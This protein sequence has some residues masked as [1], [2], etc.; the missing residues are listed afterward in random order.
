MRKCGQRFLSE[1]SP[2]NQSQPGG[3]SWPGQLAWNIY[4]KIEGL[5]I[6]FKPSSVCMNAFVLGMT[7]REKKRFLTGIPQITLPSPMHVFIHLYLYV[8]TCFISSSS[9]F[10]WESSSSS[11]PW[12]S[13]LIWLRVKTWL[14]FRVK[15]WFW[16]RVNVCRFEL[17]TTSHLYWKKQVGLG[18]EFLTPILQLLLI[19]ISLVLPLHQAVPHLATKAK[20]T[21]NQETLKF[22]WEPTFVF[23]TVLFIIVLVFYH[24]VSPISRPASQEHLYYRP[25]QSSP[26][27]GRRQCWSA[28]KR[29]KMKQTWDEGVNKLKQNW[30]QE[31]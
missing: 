27:E 11:F 15:L 14:G 23:F 22:Y 8:C 16:S 20:G 6:Y 25:P 19:G 12:A 21:D 5:L 9:V 24:I 4:N 31:T 1:L 28:C 18:F 10:A 13:L 30:D 29:K 26:C 2:C 7:S 17:F 3:D